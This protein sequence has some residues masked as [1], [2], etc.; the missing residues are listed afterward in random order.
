MMLT[1]T[2]LARMAAL[3]LEELKLKARYADLVSTDTRP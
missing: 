3:N 2:A 1:D